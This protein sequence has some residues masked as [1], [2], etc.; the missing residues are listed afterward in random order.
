MECLCARYYGVRNEL[1]PSA[2]ANQKTGQNIRNTHLTRGSTQ[3]SDPMT[4]SVSVGKPSRLQWSSGVPKD[5]HPD[6]WNPETDT[7]EVI[8]QRKKNP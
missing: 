4:A 3:D 5:L 7:T 1:R 6:Q 8:H 2:T